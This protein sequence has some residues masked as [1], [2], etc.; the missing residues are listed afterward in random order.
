MFYEDAD[1]DVK[2]IKF[3]YELRHACNLYGDIIVSKELK[4]DIKR[5]ETLYMSNIHGSQEVL[6]WLRQSDEIFGNTI[7]KLKN[8]AYKD[9]QARL[10]ALYKNEELIIDLQDLRISFAGIGTNK[11][12]RRLNKLAKTCEFAKALR[13]ALEIEDR[14]IQ[15]KKYVGDYKDKAYALKEKLIMELQKVFSDNQWTHGKQKSDIFCVDY[16]V[17]FEIPDCKENSTLY[18]LE[19]AVGKL[20]KERN[21]L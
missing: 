16:V 15:A 17:Y 8:E 6:S 9:E 1:I 18:K 5:I 7:K 12:K 14:S 20:L 11:A 19:D 13:L 21:L 4:T 2:A 3:L 10:E